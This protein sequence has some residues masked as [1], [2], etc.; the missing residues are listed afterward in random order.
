M[1]IDKP[2][3][4]KNPNG[5]G[6]LFCSRSQTQ[7]SLNSTIL[8]QPRDSLGPLLCVFLHLKSFVWNQAYFRKT[9]ILKYKTFIYE[10]SERKRRDF[11]F[12]FFWLFPVR[13][14]KPSGKQSW[15]LRSDLKKNPKPSWF[16]KRSMLS[17]AVYRDQFY[18]LLHLHCSLPRLQPFK[19]EFYLGR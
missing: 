16:I 15:L 14:I 19:G 17:I 7:L 13:M 18:Q 5:H 2:C 4:S 8:C 6:L 1:R 12:F 10:E 3:L 9:K 11:S